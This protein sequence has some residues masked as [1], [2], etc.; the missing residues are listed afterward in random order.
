MNEVAVVTEAETQNIMMQLMGDA[1]QEIQIDFLKINHDGEDKQGRDVAKGSMSLSNQGEPVYTKEAK[2]HVLAQYF[3]YREQDEKGKVQNK[4]ILQT[5][6]RKGQPIDMKGTLRCGKPTRKTLDQMSEDDKKFWA[7]KVKTT[8]IIRGVISY[9]GKTVDGKEVTVENVP[10]QHYM[11]GSG[12]NEF[13]SIIESLPSGKKFH[14]YIINVKTEKRGKYYYTTYSV[15]FGTQA[16]FTPELAATAKIFVDMANQENGRITK[17]HND[18]LLESTSDNQ[19]FDAVM[20][21]S[22][23]AADLA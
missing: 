1:E 3:Q 4:S 11:K 9:T 14:D 5:D 23:L 12:Y 13:E 17:R 10:F 8:R 6:F 22:D 21:S 20:S 19:V 7:S 15:D 18:A 2:I 16:A